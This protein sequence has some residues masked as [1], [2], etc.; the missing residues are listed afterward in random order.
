MNENYKE[1]YGTLILSYCVGTDAFCEPN[2][3]G[4]PLREYASVEIAI[5]HDGIVL[6]PEFA[7][8]GEMQL[9]WESHERPVARF[10]KWPD[11][12]RIRAILAQRAGCAVHE[13]EGPMVN[14][15]PRVPLYRLL[16]DFYE[17]LWPDEFPEKRQ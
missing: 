13:P 1:R 5:L 7:G 16:I 6:R 8:L 11:V 4:L 14:T 3:D 9:L 17:K 10:V 2:R 15:D 12:D